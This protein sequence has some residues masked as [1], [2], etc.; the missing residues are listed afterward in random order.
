MLLLFLELRK[1]RKKQR[2]RMLQQRRRRIIRRD[3]AGISDE[4]LNSALQ[5]NSLNA[6]IEE[7]KSQCQ[8]KLYDYCSAPN[9][10]LH[11]PTYLNLYTNN[12]NYRDS[13][14]ADYSNEND[15]DDSADFSDIENSIDDP[16]KLE[17]VISRQR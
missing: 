17:E 6:Y 8:Y 7:R 12:D 11:C 3:V 10:N 4:Q 14:D 2:Q 1:R 13:A 16:V 9:C 5:S 15:Y